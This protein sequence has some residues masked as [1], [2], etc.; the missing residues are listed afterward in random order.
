MQVRYESSPQAVSLMNTASL[1]DN[2]LVEQLFE[3]NAICWT[4]SHYDRVMVGGAS[5]VNQ[6]VSLQTPDPLKAMFFLERREMGIINIG[7]PGKVMADGQAFSVDRLG[8]VYLGKGT[9]EVSFSSTDPGN[10][11]LFYLLSSPAHHTYPNRVITKE[12]ASPATVGSSQT[13]N[14]RTIYK[15]IHQEGIQSCQLVMGLTLLQPGSVWNTMPAHT[16]DRRMEMYFYFAIPEGQQV[17][18]LMGSPQETR[19]LWIAN[20]QAVISPP[21]SIHAGCGTSNY[22]FIWGMAGEN[23]DY[24]DMD[25]VPIEELR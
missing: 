8:C 7:G 10:P 18:H 21:W 2:F 20:H 11:A 4:Y 12:E 15:Y 24:T 25:T 19:H 16:H 23:K 9:K 22:S 3:N 17:L 5:P 1:R 14:H 6:Q 13:S